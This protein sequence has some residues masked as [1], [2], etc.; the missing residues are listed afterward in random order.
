MSGSGCLLGDDA[1][2][3]TLFEDLSVIVGRDWICSTMTVYVTKM[4][5]MHL[6]VRLATDSFH[7]LLYLTR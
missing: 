1:V 6:D 4:Y 2:S 5:S 3:F 7:S